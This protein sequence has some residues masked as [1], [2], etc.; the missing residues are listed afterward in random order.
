MNTKDYYMNAPIF[1]PQPQGEVKKKREY[2]KYCYL[3]KRRDCERWELKVRY[4]GKVELYGGL[5]RSPEEALKVFEQ[6]FA[7]PPTTFVSASSSR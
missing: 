5:H 4:P 3:R 2:P 7:L 1:T 6:Y